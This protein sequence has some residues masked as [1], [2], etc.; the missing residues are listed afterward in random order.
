MTAIATISEL[1]TLSKTQYRIYDVSRKIDKISKE[2]FTKIELNQLPYP[3]PSQGHAFIAI[4]FWQKQTPA[5]Y[6]WFVKLPLDE[7]GLLNQ[8][9]RDHFIA[10]IVEA[11]GS[12]VTAS[13]STQ[14]ESLLKNNP[15]HF[16]P[17]Q[18]KLASLNSKIKV[19]LKQESSAYLP[20]CTRY[21][22]GE[23][24][25][26]KWQKVGVQGITDFAA[27]I[28]KSEHRN[29]FINALPN[30]ANEVLM[31]LC[32]AL[33]N[34]PLSLNIIDTIIK[35]FEEKSALQQKSDQIQQALLRSLSSSCDHPHVS[36]FIATL[37]QSNNLTSE[38]LI[39]LS[40]RCWLI[41]QDKIL[42]LKYL[43]QLANHHDLELFNAIFRDLVAIPTIRT[44]L[45]QCIR[46]PDRSPALAHAIGQLFT[47]T[48]VH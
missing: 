20:Q 19:E 43:E 30:L 25:W 37:L 41:F 28:H 36:V 18:Y 12:E 13:P 40:G 34:E 4:A 33:E 22:S 2:Q 45:L 10:I 38:L 46:E 1:L 9:A 6:L 26:D 47:S 35:T 48:T 27:R 14:Q 23:L 29:L 24:G 32:S 31:P 16:T 8:G 3:T 21:L 5:P 42:L 7:K 15:Y 44:T 39:I 11:L 17:S